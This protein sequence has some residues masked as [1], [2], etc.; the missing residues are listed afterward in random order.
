MFTEQNNMQHDRFSECNNAI[1]VAK[2]V[3]STSFNEHKHD[4]IGGPGAA[5]PGGRDAGL[6]YGG[7]IVLPSDI[8]TPNPRPSPHYR[9]P[10][11]VLLTDNTCVSGRLSAL[12]THD[13]DS[14]HLREGTLI[15]CRF[16]H[17]PV[18]PF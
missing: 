16:F 7:V 13:L 12:A 8:I 5:C 1:A 4:K 3:Q 10:T 15:F 17:A 2:Q 11:L 14:N 18:T 9:A 6:S